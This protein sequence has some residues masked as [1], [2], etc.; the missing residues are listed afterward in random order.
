MNP[1]DTIL[2]WSLMALAV[3]AAAW[4]IYRNYIL[5]K[6]SQRTCKGISRVLRSMAPLREWKVLD[7]VTLSDKKGQVTADH[8]VI[9]PFGVLVL[10]DIHHAGG[11]YGDLRDEEWVVSTAGED[12]PETMRIRVE[13]PVRRGERFVAAFR[14][15]LTAGEIYNVQVDALCPVTQKKAEVYVTGAAPVTVDY[16][17]LREALSRE[18]YQKDNHVDVA[19]VAALVEEKRVK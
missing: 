1:T 17:H 3:L 13:N 14:A 11:H 19:K 6:K 12:K 16:G 7:D 2:Y 5:K 4:A 10:T 18:R 8:L 9:G 15:I